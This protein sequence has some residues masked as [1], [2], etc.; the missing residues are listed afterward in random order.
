MKNKNAEPKDAIVQKLEFKP[1]IEISNLGSV[2]DQD[3]FWDVEDRV[4]Q[5][6]D[7]EDIIRAELIRSIKKCKRRPKKAR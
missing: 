6:I 7:N 3:V 5:E 2:I 4:N 1:R